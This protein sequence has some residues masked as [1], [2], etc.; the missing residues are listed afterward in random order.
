VR[1]ATVTVGDVLLRKMHPLL[2]VPLSLFAGVKRMK[3][4]GVE[5]AG[6]VETVGQG[7]SRFKPGDRV[8]G[9]TTGASTGANAE[10]VCLAE[11]RTTGVMAHMPA[12][13][14][15]AEAAAVPVG[16]MT[17]LQLLRKANVQR[18]D[19][20]LIYG[21]SGSVGTYAVQLARH[22]GAV[23]TGVCSTRNVELVRSLGAE[24]VI[25]YTQADF[26]AGG[27]TYDVIFDAVG[28]S[29]QARRALKAGGRL[30]SVASPTKERTEDLLFLRELVEAG[31]L[32]AVID[33]RYSLAQTAE[34]HRYVE[35]G[36][37]R[38]NVVVTVEHEQ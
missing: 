31:A 22:L 11:E 5:F 18:G 7:V 17:A 4:P 23:V 3:I 28:K 34:A 25:D 15:Y 16:G 21:A 12:K 30:V 19:H 35:T 13:L 6:Q 24:H 37:K 38:G 27:Q 29:S 33:R 1:A 14:D 8:F 10:Y 9:T 36:R 32:K 26:T 2:L 20:V